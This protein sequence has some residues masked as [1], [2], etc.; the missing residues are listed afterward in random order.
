MFAESWISIIAPWPLTVA[1]RVHVQAVAAPTRSNLTT[2]RVQ[3][4]K[5]TMDHGDDAHT[6]Q[7]KRSR[8]TR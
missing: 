7:G 4:L 3:E 1:M 6:V 2:R 8:R 5:Q